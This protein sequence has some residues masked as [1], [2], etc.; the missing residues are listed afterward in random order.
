[1]EHW[2]Q[3]DVCKASRQ[4][5][6]RVPRISIQGRMKKVLAPW[7]SVTSRSVKMEISSF[8]LS[9]RVH[10]SPEVSSSESIRSRSTIKG[11]IVPFNPSREI[12]QSTP[13]VLPCLC[14]QSIQPFTWQC[15]QDL[16]SPQ[17]LERY[18]INAWPGN[19]V[20]NSN[21]S[22]SPGLIPSF[23]NY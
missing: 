1:M 22:I 12:L 10:L 23:A 7:N 20:S 3:V 5:S 2:V 13:L 6:K 21:P 14:D 15:F 19:I 11:A 9:S 8:L 17:D 16:T 4:R 18:D